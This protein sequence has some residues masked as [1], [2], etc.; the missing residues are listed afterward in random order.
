MWCACFGNF[1]M[2]LMSIW[3]GRSLPDFLG[4]RFHGRN[5]RVCQ[6]RDSPLNGKSPQPKKNAGQMGQIGKLH[7]KKRRVY[8]S[9]FR[10]D[11]QNLACFTLLG[12]YGDGFPNLKYCHTSFRCIL[13]KPLC[14]FNSG[15]FRQL[16]KTSLVW[17]ELNE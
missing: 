17:Q 2:P 1:V 10:P 7:E 16:S 5:P 12:K 14:I 15:D 3:H 11:Y 4:K 13:R 6:G 8:L 9:D